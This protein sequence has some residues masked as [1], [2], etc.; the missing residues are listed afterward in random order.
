MLENDANLESETGLLT[1]C[2]I[3]LWIYSSAWW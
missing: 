3:L 1:L 2:R